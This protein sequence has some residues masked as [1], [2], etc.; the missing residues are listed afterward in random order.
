MCNIETVPAFSPQVCF[1]ECVTKE[2]RDDGTTS[3]AFGLGNGSSCICGS[4]F[5]SNNYLRLEYSEDDCDSP[6]AGSKRLNCGGSD[7]M[8]VFSVE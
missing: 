2:F 5:P 7:S 1:N 6:C 4:D 8:S 3:A